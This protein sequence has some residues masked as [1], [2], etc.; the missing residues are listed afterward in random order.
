MFADRILLVEGRTEEVLI[1]PLVATLAE[2]SLQSVRVGLVPLGS[3]DSLG[4]SMEI[5][6][7]MDLPTRAVVDLDFAFKGGID[8]G[9]RRH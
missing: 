7:A 5:L 3:V 2:R 6:R 1:P 9:F 4:K 8:A